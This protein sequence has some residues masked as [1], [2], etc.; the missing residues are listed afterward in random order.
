M[1]ALQRETQCENCTM[2]TLL[3]L[4]LWFPIHPVE[5]GGSPYYTGP[6]AQTIHPVIRP[7]S[8]TATQVVSRQLLLLDNL[9]KNAIDFRMP[10][11]IITT[12]YTTF[13]W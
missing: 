8:C 1:S 7:G 6:K 4:S 3:S 5:V 12:S 9:C 13:L 10:C 11:H 2:K